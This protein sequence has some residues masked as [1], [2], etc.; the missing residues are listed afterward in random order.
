ME[1]GLRYKEALQFAME[2]HAGAFRKGTD[3][4]YIEHAI[5]TSKIAAMMTDDEDVIMDEIA[6]LRHSCMML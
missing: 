4:P 6:L 3:I 2:A 5:E 1:N